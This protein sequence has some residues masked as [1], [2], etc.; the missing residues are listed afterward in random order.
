VA[1]PIAPVLQGLREGYTRAPTSPF[2]LPG[3]SPL[4]LPGF[5]EKLNPTPTNPYEGQGY[6]VMPFTKGATGYTGI[7]PE[8]WSGQKNVQQDLPPGFHIKIYKPSVAGNWAYYGYAPGVQGRL[9]G[10]APGYSGAI[11]RMTVNPQTQRV[12]VA[13][14][15]RAWQGKGIGSALFNRAQQD[16]PKLMHSTTLSPAGLA[17]AASTMGYNQGNVI[18]GVYRAPDEDEPKFTSILKDLYTGRTITEDYPHMTTGDPNDTYQYALKRWK[19]L[20]PG[21]NPFFRPGGV[22]Q[23]V[24]PDQ[25]LPE[26]TYGPEAPIDAGL[27][28]ALGQGLQRG[29]D[30]RYGQ[31]GVNPRAWLYQRPYEERVV[32]ESGV[33]NPTGGYTLPSQDQIDRVRAEYARGNISRQEY[34][35]FRNRVAWLRNQQARR[36]PPGV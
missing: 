2:G 30:P 17:Y 29:L 13:D 33:Q 35:S 22:P 10:S 25:I 36:N 5:K 23:N 4:R 24:S 18:P 6:S 14:T 26:P 15:E 27:R 3:Y 1:T 20:K 9:G 32:P 11:S 34:L 19:T 7:D 21:T 16:F 12:S 28:A 31:T 8:F